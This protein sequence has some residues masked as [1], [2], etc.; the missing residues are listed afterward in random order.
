MIVVTGATGNVG[1][2]VVDILSRQGKHVR[3]LSRQKRHCQAGREVEW[4]QADFTDAH[5]LR[6]AL[7]GAA[8]LVLI[9]PAH[10]D[11][12]AHQEALVDAAV[13]AGVRR[14]VKLSGLGA[15][16]GAPIRL[17]QLHFAIEQRISKTKIPHSF[18][19]PNLFMQVLLG[20][21]QSI[22]KDGAI[23][24]P[25]GAGAISF[26]D[27][28]DVAACIVAEVLR[29]DHVN[30]ICE[31]TGPEALTYSQVA[32]LLSKA[33]GRPVRH[34]DVTPQQAREAMVGSGMDA[35]LADAFVELFDI[36][37][38]GHGATVLSAAVAAM[39]SRPATSLA[40]F[41]HDHAAQFKKA[42]AAA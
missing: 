14:I 24:A 7:E 33:A 20:A 36:Y 19:R 8:R 25:A 1:Q 6:H 40:K 32:E 10:R 39:T 3:A 42:Q 12:Q 31:V 11:M 16:P 26:I 15:G 18:I 21:A 28:R 37:R 23:Y 29:D 34:V 5:S 13:S 30:A 27:A 9:S 4:V 2:H 22:A 41:A 17:P 35:W 38:A